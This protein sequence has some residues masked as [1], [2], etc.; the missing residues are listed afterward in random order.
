[1][2]ARTAAA[3]NCR[4]TRR[5]IVRIMAALVFCGKQAVVLALGSNVCDLIEA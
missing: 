2:H 5:A 1:M 4:R 3:N